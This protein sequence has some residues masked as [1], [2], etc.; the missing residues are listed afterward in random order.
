MKRGGHVMAT[1]TV[2]RFV[3]ACTAEGSAAQLQLARREV[4]DRRPD[5]VRL[6]CTGI[7]VDERC[8]GEDGFTTG[9]LIFA[10]GDR[11]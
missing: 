9:P 11:R 1:V 5:L 8:V 10:C 6:V 4:F 3:G 2:Y 7:D